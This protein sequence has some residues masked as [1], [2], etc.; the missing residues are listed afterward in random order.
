MTIKVE[1]DPSAVEAEAVVSPLDL[2]RV[3]KPLSEGNVGEAALQAEEEGQPRPTSA[4]STPQGLRGQ[5]RH[6]S[7]RRS[8]KSCGEKS[9][10]WQSGHSHSTLRMSLHID[11]L[12][13]GFSVR[14]VDWQREA[15][16]HEQTEQWHRSGRGHDLSGAGLSAAQGQVAQARDRDFDGV[17][18]R[19][20]D[21]ISAIQATIRTADC[22]HDA[23]NEL[24]A[25]VTDVDHML[26]HVEVLFS[27]ETHRTIVSLKHL[28]V[29]LEMSSSVCAIYAQ[30]PELSCI[31]RL[32]GGESKLRALKSAGEAEIIKQTKAV[33]TYATAFLLEHGFRASEL[34]EFRHRDLPLPPGLDSPGSEKEGS[35]RFSDAIVPL[36]TQ[37]LRD[38]GVRTFRRLTA[39]DLPPISSSERVGERPSCAESMGMDSSMGIIT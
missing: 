24:D 3:G 23:F 35:R 11:K 39:S 28:C 7:S 20:Y 31:S 25:T 33:V 5:H 17:F 37:S 9:K 22:C 18:L 13:M 8:S 2:R 27:G 14:T 10:M 29:Q 12:A 30:Q 21:A 16:E 36:Q 34:R 6:L 32:C 19:S 26:R 38:I 1:P 4:P 15:L